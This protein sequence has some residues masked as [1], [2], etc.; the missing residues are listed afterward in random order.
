MKERQYFY[1]P[2]FVY[3]DNVTKQKNRIVFNSPMFWAKT[4]DE[5][6]MRGI[7]A[8]VCG[9]TATFGVQ[10][11]D[12]WTLIR[13]SSGPFVFDNLKPLFLDDTTPEIPIAIIAGPLLDKGLRYSENLK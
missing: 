1:A 2:V 8:E 12:E 13:K 4:A 11:E 5:A 9:F 7:Y 6:V 10:W 3:I